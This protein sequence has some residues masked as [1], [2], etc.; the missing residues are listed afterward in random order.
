MYFHLLYNQVR[1]QLRRLAPESVALEVIRQINEPAPD[2]LEELRKAVWQ[3]LLLVK[4]A[5]QENTG[6]LAIT[7]NATS[8]DIQQLRQMLWQVQGHGD[9]PI[10]A[11]NTAFIFMRQLLWPQVE[12]QKLETKSLVREEAIL[13]RLSD[14]H[15]LK[16]L[17]RNEIGL[18]PEVLVDL[19]LAVFS[20]LTS[21]NGR[22]SRSFLDP[23]A[24]ALGSNVVQR[25]LSLMALDSRG[26]TEFCSGL[27]GQ[28]SSRVSSEYFE[29]PALT[30][31]PLLL[32]SGG[33]FWWHRMV[34]ARGLES[35]LHRKLGR[36]GQKYIDLYGPVFE[37]YVIGMLRDIEIE[38]KTES[39][40][41][42]AFGSRD[43]LTDGLCVHSKANILIECK[44][45]LYREDRM[46]VGSSRVFLH[47]MKSIVR[48]IQQAHSVS[49][50]I[51]DRRAGP[52]EVNGRHPDY[53][54]I[55][56]NIDLLIGNIYKF[57]EVF[58]P[59]IAE[60]KRTYPKSN[61]PINNI[62]VVSV[63]E[64]ERLVSLLK[65]QGL[66]F[67]DFLS[68]ASNEDSD[69]RTAKFTMDQHVGARGGG[70]VATAVSDTVEASL[71]RMEELLQE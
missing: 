42:E 67:F 69:H 33:F 12:L 3:S 37:A 26:L 59:K 23:L 57:K 9:S 49:H 54:L 30:E 2:S 14:S 62:F 4:W 47:K 64:W 35:F 29:A 43:K 71:M 7:R 52:I 5:F 20:G 16:K 48:A 70:R 25:F 41:C 13:S 61:L 32:V 34:F 65:D 66:D 1:L 36:A 46:T 18:N 17:I 45:L 38:Y 31:Y 44:S 21:G 68:Q 51:R 22:M 15:R 55:V 40:L 8:Q 60:F 10:G 19:K 11:H 28:G 6:H 56:T 63:D 39:E 24:R 53:L 58:G 50:L 27:P